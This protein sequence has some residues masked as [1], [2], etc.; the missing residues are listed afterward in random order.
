MKIN[1]SVPKARRSRARR[2][3]PSGNPTQAEIRGLRSDAA[4]PG[5]LVSLLLTAAALAMPSAPD[6]TGAAVDAANQSWPQWRG[7]LGTGVAPAANPPTTWSET[8]NVRWKVRLPGNG[9]GTPIIWN[10]RVFVQTAVPTGRKVEKAGEKAAAAAAPA[11]APGGRRRPGGMGG[12]K[13]T[14][15]YQFRVLC[16]DR[17]NGDIRWQKTA[18]EQVPQEGFR[19]GDGSFAS[20]SPV[21]D[22]EHLYA[23][24][25]SRGLYCYS[26]EGELVWSQDLGDMRIVMSFGEGSSPALYGDTLVVNWDHEG[27]CFIVALDKK[28]GQTLW[29]NPREEKTS[30]STPLVVQVEGRPQVVTAAT[31]KIR[32]YDLSTGKLMW[33]CGGLTS[34]VI[35]TPVAE[36]NVLYAMS[37]F[38]GNSLLAIRLGRTGDLTGTDAIAWT[39]GKSTPYVPSP[40]LYGGRLYFFASNNGILSC[41]EAKSGRPLFAA[42]RLDAIPGVYASPV[43][44][45]G[46]VYLT[47]RN[48]VALVLKQADTLE[49]VATNRLDEKFDAS[50]AAAGGEL[51]LR[52]QEFLYCI[53]V[54]K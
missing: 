15:S 18:C 3:A 33:E 28:T 27:D 36:D 39:Y 51:F 53:A 52:G 37:G 5:S 26:L 47:G 22:G 17:A 48:G 45:S 38:R 32:S 50:P 34:N 54:G 13:P 44:A 30:W 41:F 31:R 19:A 1:C 8:N 10:D 29:R 23:F 43:G 6:C 25:G 7:P 21:T 14:E 2:F 35:P 46:R 40:L 42:E 16:L 4:V 12:E 11:E 9:K 24:F 49:I 20:G